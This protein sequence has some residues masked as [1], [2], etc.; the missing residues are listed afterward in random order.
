MNTVF[1]LDKLLPLLKDF[2]A[3]ARV[4][5]T[6]FDAGLQEIASYPEEV[7]PLCRVIRTTEAGR[8]A[9]VRCD[10]EACAKAQTARSSVIYRCHAGLTEAVTPLYAENLHI[11]YLLIGHAFA[12]ASHAEGWAAVDRSCAQLPVDRGALHAACEQSPLL[13]QDYI[14]SAAQ[15]MHAVAS[16]LVLERMAALQEDPLAARLNALVTAHYADPISAGELCERLGIGRTQLYKLSH[17]LYG[18]GIAEQLRWLRL[19]R[20]RQLLTG[21]GRTIAEIAAECGF[22][23]YN[24]FIA[25]FTREVGCSPGAYRRRG[26]EGLR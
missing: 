10:R 3:I 19:E 13:T 11:G 8:E 17:Q 20:A 9:C 24:Y 23:D 4:R 22:G 14:R 21:S 25:V 26:R 6:V 18:R 2:Y 1:A 16:Y 5:I 7:A 12:Y 15:I